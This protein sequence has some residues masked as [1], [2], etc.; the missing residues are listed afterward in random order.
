MYLEQTYGTN[1][2]IDLNLNY[3]TYKNHRMN[4]YEIVTRLLWCRVQIFTFF[5]FTLAA[6]E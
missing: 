4:L 6:A 2:T 1:K 3:M 5:N